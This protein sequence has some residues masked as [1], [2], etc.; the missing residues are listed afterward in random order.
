M[1]ENNT[2]QQ[3]KS[4]SF[5]GKSVNYSQKQQAPRSFLGESVKQFKKNKLAVASLFLVVFIMLLGVMAPYIALE[6]PV[7]P[8][9]ENRLQ[10]GFW[11]GNFDNPLGTDELGRDIF[12]RIVYGTQISLKVGYTVV[13]IAAIFGIL[14][15]LISAYYGGIIDLILMRITDIFLSFPPLLLALTVVAILG[16][17][18]EN[19]MLA[20]ALIYIPQLARIVRSSVLTVKELPYVEASRSLGAKNYFIIFGHILPNILAPSVVYLTLLLA[21]AVLYTAALGFLGV[22][23]DPSTPEWGAMLSNGRDYIILGYWWL[24][25]FPGMMIAISVFA[26]N[27][28]GD[29]LREALDP[30]MDV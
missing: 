8:S 23:I 15:G 18:L 2:K 14:L 19:A 13:V 11:T 28:F 7:E 21:D 6:D 12:S 29:G 24:T 10:P 26:F 1:T 4:T 25:V 16:T 30:K 27:L 5:S 22:G 17:G 20:I 3:S 9:P